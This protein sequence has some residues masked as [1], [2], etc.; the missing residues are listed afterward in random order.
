LPCGGAAETLVTPTERHNV[1]KADFIS[2]SV[3]PAYGF[4]GRK[5]DVM[6][7]GGAGF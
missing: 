4:N 5:E 3:H 1:A 6:G 2:R 7:G